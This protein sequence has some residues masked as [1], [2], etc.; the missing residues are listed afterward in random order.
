MKTFTQTIATDS[1]KT[2][3]IA[4][5][6]LD[7]NSLHSGPFVVAKSAW[8]IIT[9]NMAIILSNSKFDCRGPFVMEVICGDTNFYIE[10]FIMKIYGQYLYTNAKLANNPLLT[11]KALAK[12][13]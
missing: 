5:A 13:C 1:K 4:L 2:L 7:K 3:A 6:G 10:N 11:A 9:K 12:F 8:T